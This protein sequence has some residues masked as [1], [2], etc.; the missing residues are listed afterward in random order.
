MEDESRFR[1]LL[2]GGCLLFVLMGLCVWMVLRQS[3]DTVAQTPPRPKVFKRALAEDLRLTRHGV[4]GVDFVR[5]GACRLEKRKRGALTFGGFNVLVLEDLSVV[6][7]PDETEKEPGATPRGDEGARSVVRRM[8]ISEDFLSGRGIPFKFS[9]VRVSKLEVNRLEGSNTVVRVFTASGAE[10]VREGLS[11]TGC[12]VFRGR[13]DAG[14]LV[15]KARL[16]LTGGKLRLIWPGGDLD[17][18]AGL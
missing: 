1:L 10:S 7:P 3:V 2:T 16:K 12:R 5:C 8:G 6:L 14:E 18:Q 4:Y 9:S 13:D 17:V 15:G 11:L